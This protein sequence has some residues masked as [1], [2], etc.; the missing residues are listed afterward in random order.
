MYQGAVGD[1]AWDYPII[2]VF[3]L[4]AGVVVFHLLTRVERGPAPFLFER[5]CTRCK[6]RTTGTAAKDFLY[7]PF[8]AGKY[9]PLR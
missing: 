1:L 9:P 8:C 6:L 3:A 2:I 4:A 7:C 5:V